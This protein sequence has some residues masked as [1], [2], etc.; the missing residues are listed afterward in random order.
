MKITFYK[1]TYLPYAP[2]PSFRARGDYIIDGSESNP[3]PEFGG[4]LHSGDTYFV[5]FSTKI[6]NKYIDYPIHLCMVGEGNQ[7][8]LLSCKSSPTPNNL[9]AANFVSSNSELFIS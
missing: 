3:K 9:N 4:T 8:I 5:S 2:V 1:V 6:V 7:T